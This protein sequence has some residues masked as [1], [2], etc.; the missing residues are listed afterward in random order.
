[1]S[2]LPDFLIAGAPRSGSTTLY[3]MIDEHPEIFMAKPKE[4]GFFSGW[5]DEDLAWYEAHFADAGGAQQAGEATP[6]YLQDHNAVDEI[7]QVIPDVKIIVILRDP[8]DRTY[9]HYWMEK[10]R[11]RADASFEEYLET[12]D[13]LDVSLYAAHLSY[14]TE[15]FPRDQILVL[16]HEDL[17]NDPTGLYTD[18]CEFLG[19]DSA[20]APLALGRTVNQYVEFRS[21]RVRDW[22]KALPSSLVFA[23]RIMDRA[24]TRTKVSY[25]QMNQATRDRL[26]RFYQGPNMDLA[27]WLDRDLPGWTGQGAGA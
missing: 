16:F 13:V 23:R 2:R 17:K 6:W 18:V 20:Y 3:R 7:A 1:M 12:S 25:P 9:S 14:M 11:G 8:V 22:A 15:H 5:H 27:R 19:V 24:N 21:M 10:V 4:I 26:E